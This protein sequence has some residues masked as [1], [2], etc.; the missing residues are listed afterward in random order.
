[1]SGNGGILSLGSG[2]IVF[3]IENQKVF[4]IASSSVVANL[5]RIESIGADSKDSKLLDRYHLAECSAALL[6][7]VPILKLVAFEICD[8]T[9]AEH[10]KKKG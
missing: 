3:L 7:K 10:F 2:K 4:A 9:F 1:M 8:R 6:K 5:E